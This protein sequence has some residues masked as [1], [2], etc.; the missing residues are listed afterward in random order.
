MDTKKGTIDNG[1]YLRVESGRRVRTEKLPIGY[2]V[3]YLANGFNRSPN[4]SNTKYVHIT[5]LHTY[6]L[7]LKKNVK[8]LYSH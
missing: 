5:N 2:Y 7:N 1:A 4:L 8:V 6:P 3:R